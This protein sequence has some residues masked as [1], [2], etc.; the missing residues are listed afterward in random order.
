MLKILDKL[1]F[2]YKI[3]KLKVQKDEILKSTALKS[4][5]AIV[6]GSEAKMKQAEAELSKESARAYLA[7]L[8]IKV[9]KFFACFALPWF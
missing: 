6:S 5:Q 1:K 4:V 9:N 7:I 3:D 8:V 2:L